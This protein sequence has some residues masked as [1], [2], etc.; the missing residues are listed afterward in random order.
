MIE[1][2]DSDEYS[3][4]YRLAEFPGRAEPCAHVE[5]VIEVTEAA[6]TD[7]LDDVNIRSSEGH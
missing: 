1:T 6:E 4:S 5:N 7:A 3:V 2:Q